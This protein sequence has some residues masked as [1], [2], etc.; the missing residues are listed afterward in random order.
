MGALSLE[1]LVVGTAEGTASADGEDWAPGMFSDKVS[2]GLDMMDSRATSGSIIA[3]VLSSA[4]LSNSESRDAMGTWVWL[5][6]FSFP[7]PFLANPLFS[8][9]GTSCS[10]KK[11]REKAA[12]AL[13]MNMSASI[14]RCRTNWEFTPKGDTYSIWGLRLTP[15][16]V[17]VDFWRNEVFTGEF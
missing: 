3:G 6:C 13:A 4:S 8:D 17:E 1:L 7:L 14:L 11:N 16:P 12:V 10:V 15:S 9:D 2:S 5:D